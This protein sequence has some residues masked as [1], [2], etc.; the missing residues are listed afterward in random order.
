MSKDRKR[1]YAF[2]AMA[3]IEVTGWV[4]GEQ[5]IPGAR[6]RV[7]RACRLLRETLSIEHPDREP[8]VWIVDEVRVRADTYRDKFGDRV[9][10]TALALVGNWHRLVPSETMS[11]Y[12]ARM[13]YEVT[14]EEA[15]DAS[16]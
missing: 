15:H 5:L 14:E 1:D 7:N 3:E 4:A 16:S 10:L 12:L 9:E 11:E 6:S 2:E 13:G 8:G